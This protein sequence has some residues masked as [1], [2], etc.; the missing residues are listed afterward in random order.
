VGEDHFIKYDVPIELKRKNWQKI[1]DTV[2]KG[3]RDQRLDLY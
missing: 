2:L 3:N 1:A